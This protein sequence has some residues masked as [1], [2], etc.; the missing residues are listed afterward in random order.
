VCNALVSCVAPRITALRDVARRRPAL[1]GTIALALLATAC[2]PVTPLVEPE[3]WEFEGLRVVS[4]VPD[5]PV[6]VAY[7]FHGS[8]GSA[9]FADKVETV[10]VLNELTARSYAWIATE[11][12]ERTGDKRWEVRDPSLASNP[13]L[14]RLVR[15][16]AHLVATSDVDASTPLVGVGMS[17][18]ARFVTLWGQTWADAGYPVAAIAPYMGRIAAPVEA[19]GGLRVPAYFVTAQNDFTSP[20]GPIVANYDATLALG[21]PTELHVAR[22]ARLTA[23]RFTRIPGVDLGASRAV[24]DALVTAGLWNAAG[25]RVVSVDEVVARA[26]TVT[27][28][29]S[30]AARRADILDQE[31]VVL[32]V[33]QMRGDRKKQMADF[34]ALHLPS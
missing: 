20:P 14:A 18:G 28:P 12:T 19:S 27:L 23:T 30:V 17:N 32:A 8:G 1:R 3:R 21:T 4:Y 22:E 24:F 6:A 25:D 10:D 2:G 26:P 9:A 15:L 13:D 11:S 31:A 7:V 34:F 33:H 5:E 29:T 16:H